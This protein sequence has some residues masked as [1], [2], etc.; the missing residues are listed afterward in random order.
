MNYLYATKIQNLEKK[1]VKPL[2]NLVYGCSDSWLWWVDTT[3][4]VG[5]PTYKIG[6][7]NSGSTENMLSDKSRT[8]KIGDTHNQKPSNEMQDNKLIREP[9]SFITIESYLQFNQSPDK[10]LKNFFFFIILKKSLRTY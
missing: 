8:G 10:I 4:L 2:M 5:K 9:R 3:Y 1:E 7:I 6:N